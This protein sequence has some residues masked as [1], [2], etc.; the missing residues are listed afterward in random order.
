MNKPQQRDLI[1]TDVNGQPPESQ[2]ID[3]QFQDQERGIVQQHDQ[4]KEDKRSL[5]KSKL[6]T[7]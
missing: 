7:Y 1:E 4:E 3:N 2:D 6:P 5:R